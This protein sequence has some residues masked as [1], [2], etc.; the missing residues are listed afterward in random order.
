MSILD[1]A[2]N[3]YVNILNK[4]P[5]RI[6]VPEWDTVV[7]AK[8]S[9]PLSKLGEIMELSNQG[10]TAEAMVMTL[11]YRLIDEEGNAIFKKAEKSEL[12]RQVDPDVLSRIMTIIGENQPSQEDLEKN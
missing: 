5:I 3:H 9:I 4:E 1:K 7:Y 11:I 12:L 6:E 10:K 8:T 2:K